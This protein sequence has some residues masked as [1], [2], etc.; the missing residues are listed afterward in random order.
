MALVVVTLGS[1][2]RVDADEVLRV[3]SF[4]MWVG[5]DASRQ[6][7]ERT[8]EVVRAAKADIVGLQETGGL[9][10]Q[11]QPRPD[12]ARRLAEALGWSYHEQG[13]STGMARIGIISR[14][15]IT[16]SVGKPAIG[17]TVSLPSGRTVDVFNIHMAHAPYQPYQLLNIPYAGA[18]FLKTAEEA[19]ASANEARRAQVNEVLQALKSSKSSQQFITGDFNEPSYLDWTEEAVQALHHPLVVEWPATKAFAEAGFRDSYRVLFPDPVKHPGFTWTT[20]TKRD[21]PKDHHDRI[22]FVLSHGPAT[23]KATEIVGDS[24]ESADIVVT[25]YPS[26]HRAVVSTFV[27]EGK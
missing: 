24:Q 17:A 4:N 18:P 21:N 22:D 12:H 23:I 27:L 3:M 13:S 9:A 6:P 16:G 2:A 11:D 5:G 7:F 10:P 14:Y 1:S 20:L 8:V 26:D 19:V 15:P 25:P